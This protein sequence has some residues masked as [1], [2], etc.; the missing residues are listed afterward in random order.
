MKD[1]D[2]QQSQEFPSVP[3]EKLTDAWLNL[4]RIQRPR[5]GI[6]VVGRESGEDG[7][8][9]FTFRNLRTGEVSNAPWRLQDIEEGTVRQYAA[10]M[11]LNDLPIEEEKV[12]WWG[13]IG[14][15]RPMRS[16]VDLIYRDED[17]VD[18]IYYAARRDEL[19]AEW[20]DLLDEYDEV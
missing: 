15:M 16:Q 20:H 1:K 4:I 5:T 19:T 13:N 10:R 12:R 6:E 11:A 2:G 8:Q 3:R 18:H 9:R 7:E 17:G 14:Y